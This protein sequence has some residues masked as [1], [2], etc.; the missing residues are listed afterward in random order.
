VVTAPAATLD[1]VDGLI[2]QVEVAMLTAGD[3]PAEL[4]RLGLELID[5]RRLRDQALRRVL[6]ERARRAVAPERP[7]AVQQAMERLR[8]VWRP[9]VVFGRA[10]SV[11]I[12]CDG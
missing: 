4:A 8:A 3:D 12:R 2:R 7:A 5:V 1:L 11:E 9:D 6:A 10:G